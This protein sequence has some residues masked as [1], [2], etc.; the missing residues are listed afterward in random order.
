MA[1]DAI[2]MAPFA[3]HRPASENVR[4]ASRLETTHMAPLSAAATTAPA[5]P[6]RHASSAIGA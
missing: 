6:A 4:P 2:C 1:N 5:R 3:T